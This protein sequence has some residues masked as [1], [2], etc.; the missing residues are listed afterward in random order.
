MSAESSQICE[1]CGA[2]AGVTV[3][4]VP[5]NRT[6]LRPPPSEHHYCRAC[7]TAVGVPDPRCDERATPSAEPEAPTWFEIEQ[8]LASYEGILR[9]DP[10]LR[11]RVQSLAR[12]L[13][14]LTAQLPGAM[15][16]AVVAAFQRLEK[17]G[18]DGK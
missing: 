16:P 11:G 14:S 12:Q 7:A 6:G 8:H 10:S 18:A 13:R 5:P 17:A 2:P 3:A 9:D 4:A 1:R 15:P